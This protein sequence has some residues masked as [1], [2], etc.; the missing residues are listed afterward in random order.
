MRHGLNISHDKMLNMCITSK[1]QF[2][3]FSKAGSRKVKEKHCAPHRRSGAH[4][5]VR[6]EWPI[7]FELLDLS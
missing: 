7:C 6:G 1:T 5:V 2:S 4:L 3:Y